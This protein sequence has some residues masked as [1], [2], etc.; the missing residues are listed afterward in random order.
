MTRRWTAALVLAALAGCGHGV[1]F[2]PRWPD[3]GLELRDDGDRDQAI[4]QLWLVAP[5]P[6]RGRARAPI[7]AAIARRIGEAIEDDQAFVAAALLDQL[8]WLWSGD[9]AAVGR[10]LADQAAL[11]RELR[12][13]FARSG[14]LEPA[15]Q[16]LILLAEVEPAARAAR[17]AE[18]D[19]VLGFADDLAVADNGPEAVRAQPIALLEPTAL[20]LPLPWLVDRYVVLQ[21]ERQRAVAAVIEHTGASLP[22]VRAQHDVASAA[23]RI[24]GI[25]ARAGRATEIHRRLAQLA[26]GY[27]TDRELAIRAEVVADQPTAGAYAEL[28]SALATDEH[29]PD[30]AAALAVCL[31][32][33]VRFPGDPGLFAAAG[34]NARTL[35]RIDQAIALYQ[36]ALYRSGELD[37]AIALRLGKLYADRIERLATGGRPTAANAAWRDVLRFTAGVASRHPHTVWQQ[38][39]AIAESALGR[40]F[41]SQGMLDDAEHALTASLERAPSIDAL[42]TLAMIDVQTDHYAEAE[43]WAHRG[44][45]LLGNQSSGDRYRRA[46]LQR[47]S[48]DSLRRAGKSRRAAERY[49]DAL[50]TWA[51]LGDSRELPRPIAAERELDMG[52][53]MWGLGDASKAV[54]LA[55]QALDRDPQS[56]ELAA[57]TVAFLIEAGR[58]QDALDA[59]HKSLGEPA[60]DEYHKVYMSLW[61]VGEA[62]RTGEP[63][64]RLAIE[65]LASRRGNLWYEQ[66][67]QAAAHKRSLA[68]LRAA[69]TTGPRRAELAFYGASLGLDPAA[70]TPAGRRKLLEGVVA[71]RLVLDAEYDLARRYLEQPEPAPPAATRPAAPR[72]AAPRPAATRPAATRPAATSPA[73]T[74]PAATSPAATSPAAPRR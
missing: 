3:V 11:L 57:A 64:D 56:E 39:M 40:G 16:A 22:I 32:G 68:E 53:A 34:G 23:R 13:T 46:K 41:A 54:E 29:Y 21:I 43:R 4:D 74:S 6:E 12:A 72:P 45:A 52:R 18:L 33:L 8:T 59:F 1:A 48:A 47:L 44:L 61:I 67:A 28:A 14:A 19:E 9:P 5:G 10:E 73:A 51:S 35:G 55:L 2:H 58:Y 38:A 70:A 15:V 30:A 42:E 69:A 17:L 26:T 63:R 20:A 31:S 62:V 7:A 36:Q 25:L 49:L 60:I 71:A 66:L 27:G 24:A 65:Y 50:R 37:T